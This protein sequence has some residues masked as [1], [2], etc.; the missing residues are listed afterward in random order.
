MATTSRQENYSTLEVDKEKTSEPPVAKEDEAELPQ[1]IEQSAPEVVEKGTPTPANRQ[2]RICGLRK[3]IFWAILAAVILIIIGAAIGGGVGGGLAARHKSS[4]SSSSTNTTQQPAGPPQ[5]LS[6]SNIAAVNYTDAQNVTHRR[7]YFQ[8]DTTALYQSDYDASTSSWTVTPAS[9]SAATTSDRAAA[10]APK[11]ATSLSA[12]VNIQDASTND[13]NPH[14]LS[15]THQKN[16]N[17]NQPAR[18]PPL[19]HRHRRHHPRTHLQRL[20]FH[21]LD[22]LPF[23]PHPPRHHL[24][25]RL[26]GQAVRRLLRRQ[27]ARVPVAAEQREHAQRREPDRLGQRRGRRNGRGEVDC[28]GGES[29]AGEWDGVGAVVGAGWGGGGVGVVCECGEFA[30]GG[31]EWDGGGVGCAGGDG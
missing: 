27:R 2:P 15:A 31:V 1:V 8:A 19:L 17:A 24:R 29:G 18:L 30:G 7:V 3:P 14:P 22:P 25:P 12:H 23:P 26:L 4:S 16:T 21:L 9:A 28:G 11:N 20:F 10:A 5:I 6:T 13:V